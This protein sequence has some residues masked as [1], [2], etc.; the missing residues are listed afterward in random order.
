[1]LLEEQIYFGHGSLL[2]SAQIQA[3]SA[4]NCIYQC[5]KYSL[6]MFYLALTMILYGPRLRHTSVVKRT[7]V[8]WDPSSAEIGHLQFQTR[9]SFAHGERISSSATQDFC[10]FQSM[11]FVAEFYA[12]FYARTYY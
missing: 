6:P 5:I 9:C 1:M 12:D 2:D 8:L 4:R 10:F 11:S 7:S 3:W